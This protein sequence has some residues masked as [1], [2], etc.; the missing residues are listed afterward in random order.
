MRLWERWDFVYSSQLLLGHSWCMLKLCSTGISSFMRGWRFVWITKQ[1]SR[2]FVSSQCETGNIAS[3]HQTTHKNLTLFFSP[4]IQEHRREEQRRQQ[5]MQVPMSSMRFCCWRCDEI[6]MVFVCLCYLT[7]SSIWQKDDLCWQLAIFDKNSHPWNFETCRF[8][9]GKAKRLRTKKASGIHQTM[10]FLPM[11]WRGLEEVLDGKDVLRKMLAEMFFLYVLCQF[12]L[13]IDEQKV[14]QPAFWWLLLF[15]VS[16]VAI[17]ML[18]FE[19][20]LVT[21]LVFKGFQRWMTPS[22]SMWRVARWGT[23]IGFAGDFRWIGK[24]F[25]QLDLSMSMFNL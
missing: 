18:L 1:L 22:I 8:L 24:I 25:Q 14:S 23:K 12:A 5:E 4:G 21:P 13:K 16:F 6:P 2:S 9:N 20:K 10:Q 19:W 3:D 17:Y 11:K 15:A 7:I